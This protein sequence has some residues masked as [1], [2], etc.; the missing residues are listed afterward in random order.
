MALG[1]EL[2][3]PLF[4]MLGEIVRGQVHMYQGEPSAAEAFDHADGAAEAL[5]DGGTLGMVEFFQG[6]LKWRQGHLSAAY[7]LLEGANAKGESMGQY[8]AGN[9][10]ALLAELALQGMEDLQAARRHLTAASGQGPN[11]AC[12]WEGVLLATGARFA[13]GE[14]LVGRSHGLACE[15]LGAAFR[16][17][18]LLLTIELLELVA[19]TNSDLGHNARRGTPFGSCGRR[20]RKDRVR[21]DRST[22]ASDEIA[23]VLVCLENCRR[24]GGNLLISAA[25]AG[26]LQFVEAIA[27]ACRG[28]GRLTFVPC[29]GWR[30]SPRPSRLGRAPGVAEHLDNVWEIAQQLIFVSTATGG[31][32]T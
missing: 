17:G 28:R 29:P 30:A 15:G 6:D 2:S 19:I 31:R 5:G 22:Q 7:D 9:C 12:A 24:T 4:V 21:S 27:Y 23:S 1:T 26:R 8:W 20:T 32:A 3:E 11:G 16:D 10:R 13:Q 14:G 18:A 25:R